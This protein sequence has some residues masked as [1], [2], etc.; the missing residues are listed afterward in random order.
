M[1]GGGGPAGAQPYMTRC[2]DAFS[3]RLQSSGAFQARPLEQL[4]AYFVCIVQFPSHYRQHLV[5][6]Q[7]SRAVLCEYMTRC[8]DALSRIYSLP[9]H[10]TSVS[11]RTIPTEGSSTMLKT[12][13]KLE[14]RNVGTRRTTAGARRH[15]AP[16]ETRIHGKTH[17]DTHDPCLGLHG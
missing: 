12:L 5:H 2:V 10:G 15:A 1:G 9:E 7:S 17:I 6:L 11:T 13:P 14:K 3:W 16:R 8:V 4:S